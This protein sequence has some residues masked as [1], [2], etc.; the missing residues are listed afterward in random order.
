MEGI[1]VRTPQLPIDLAV[2][3]LPADEP[4]W[5]KVGCGHSGDLPIG[6]INPQKLSGPTEAGFSIF[7]LR[8]LINGHHTLE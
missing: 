1:D 8:F 2:E 5:L 6:K 3:S 4:F 7:D